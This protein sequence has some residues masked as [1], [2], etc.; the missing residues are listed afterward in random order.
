[1]KIEKILS[2]ITPKTTG[3]SAAAGFALTAASGMSKSK[4]FRKTH[5]PFAWITAGLTLLHIGQIEYYKF[6][7]KH[8][9]N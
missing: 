9:S 5:K 8:K 4:E 6:K 2:Y 1:M 3:Y 7:Y